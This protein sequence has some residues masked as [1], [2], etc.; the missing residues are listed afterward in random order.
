M[1]FFARDR[2]KQSSSPSVSSLLLAMDDGLWS[3]EDEMLMVG[4]DKEELW[5]W[6]GMWGISVTTRLYV[7]PP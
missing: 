3:F 1:L 5:A 4:F 6:R 2:V 7:L